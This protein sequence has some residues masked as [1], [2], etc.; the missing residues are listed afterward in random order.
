MH[1]LLGGVFPKQH[2]ANCG[3]IAVIRKVPILGHHSGQPLARTTRW[4]G[5]L[6]HLLMLPF[7]LYI[8]LDEENLSPNQ[9]S[10]K[11][12]A[13]RRRR[14]CEIGRV[15]KLFLAPCRRG[16]SPLEAFFITMPASGV[17]CE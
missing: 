8:L 5:H 7:R 1:I 17:M 3:V 13:S 12:T 6:D 9:F 10:L 15:H 14:R 4:Y 2:H 16:E 11:Q